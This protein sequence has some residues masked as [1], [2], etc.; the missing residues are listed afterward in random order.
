MLKEALA[1]ILGVGRTIPGQGGVEAE[2]GHG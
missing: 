2:E 1:I